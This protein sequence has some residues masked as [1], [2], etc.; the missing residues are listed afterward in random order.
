M[1]LN[2]VHALAISR[3][4][5]TAAAGAFNVG[6]P[7]KACGFVILFV[8]VLIGMSATKFLEPFAAR[9]DGNKRLNCYRILVENA[10]LA[11]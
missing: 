1:L 3:I 11:E 2:F 5:G 7:Q 6:S 10:Y 4:V 8:S 9:V